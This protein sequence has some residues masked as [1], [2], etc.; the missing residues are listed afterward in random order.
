MSFWASENKIAIGQ[1]KVAI[2]SENGLSYSAGQKIDI[3]VPREIQFFQPKECYLSLDVEIALPTGRPST[4][5]SFDEYIG[6]QVLIKDIRVYTQGG[7]LLEEIQ[8]YNTAV[9][10]MYDYDT[11]ENIRNKRAMT[12]G[13]TSSTS[14]Y[15]GTT[16]G[17][18]SDNVNHVN[19]P[20]YVGVE[21]ST[22]SASFVDADYKKAKLLLPLHTGIFQNDKIFPNSMGLRLEIVLEQ[23]NIVFRQLDSV[24]KNN[25]MTLNP[26]FHSLNGSTVPDEWTSGS[27][28]NI[29]YV[30]RDNHNIGINNFPFVVGEAIK[31]VNDTTLNLSYNNAS[32]MVIDQIEFE[33]ASDDNKGL[34]KITLDDTYTNNGS[35]V[36]PLGSGSG[37]SYL[38]SANFDNGSAVGGKT[39]NPTFTVSNVELIVQKLDMPDG[40]KKQMNQMMKEGG[41]MVYDFLSYT[42]Y[43]QTI[44]ASDTVANINLPLNFSRAKSILCV[45]TDSTVRTTGEVLSCEGA[46]VY[47]TESPDIE[48]N[49]NTRG[50]LVGIWDNLQNYQ[51]NYNNRLQPSRK[52]SCAKISARDSI[53]QQPI[54]ELEKA[55]VQAGIQPR[56]FRAFQ[57]NC[58]I[59][60]ALALQ[61]GVYDCRGKSFSLQVEYNGTA[62]QFPK[63]WNNY[64]F[65]LRRLNINADGIS[66]DL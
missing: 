11:N 1:T 35:S 57:R 23:N 49:H 7:T 36:F 44:L 26:K 32:N 42:N 66:V 58:V 18:E 19:S 43:R 4:R 25:K 8:G 17:T 54:V 55:L 12:E 20:Y 10:V 6:G 3:T 63:L 31:F 22:Q 65:H 50:G 39:Y 37:S 47:N 51:F 29:F 46:Y 30:A 38:Y 33:G 41:S 61:D 5:L 16:G 9:S 13:T 15:R 48:D 40:Y 21:N 53:D 27:D 59:G 34:L 64:V 62:P 2:P 60:R 56:S 52:I 28:A 14:F 45:P 24:N